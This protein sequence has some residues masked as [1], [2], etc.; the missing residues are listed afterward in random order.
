LLLGVSILLVLHIAI[1]PGPSRRPAPGSRRFLG[2]LPTAVLAIVYIGPLL[3]VFFSLAEVDGPRMLWHALASG[4]AQHLLTALA[5]AVP[6]SLVLYRS[7]ERRFRQMEPP[8]RAKQWDN[9]FIE[10]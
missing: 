3:P 1:H 8:P 5:V 9:W 2:P 6:L 4:L 7:L 10:I